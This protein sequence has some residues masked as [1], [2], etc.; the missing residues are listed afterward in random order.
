MPRDVRATAVASGVVS[1]PENSTTITASR[2]P[3]PAGSTTSSGPRENA[4]AKPPIVTGSASSGSAPEADREQPHVAAVD[5]PEGQRPEHP[6]GD[7]A[8]GQ[9]SIEPWPAQDPQRPVEQ[10]C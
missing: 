6:A 1:R 5:Q 8:P 7:V 9:R 4:M 2:T 10:A 3:A